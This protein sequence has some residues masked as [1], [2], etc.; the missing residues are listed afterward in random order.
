MA[1]RTGCRTDRACS[2]LLCLRRRRPTLTEGTRLPARYDG[3]GGSCWSDRVA[4]SCPHLSL[5]RPGISRLHRWRLAAALN[6]LLDFL[7]AKNPDD[8]AARERNRIAARDGVNGREGYD[9]P[10]ERVG[11][12]PQDEAVE[13]VRVN[14]ELGLVADQGFHG[15]R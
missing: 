11:I 1:P 5:T 2:L 12:A 6:N 10:H 8:V 13:K 14:L 15:R 3:S 4:G 9:F 7:E